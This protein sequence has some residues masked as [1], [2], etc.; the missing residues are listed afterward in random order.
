LDATG[1]AQVLG[2]SS[3][4]LELQPSF[5]LLPG[6]SEAAHARDIQMI[7]LRQHV[8]LELVPV[9]R[10]DLIG[11]TSLNKTHD[12]FRW[13]ERAYQLGHECA[14]QRPVKRGDLIEPDDLS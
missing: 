12:F 9:L 13:H 5:Q 3:R 11:D 7:E 2:K 8:L 6:D 14:T 1:H 10:L 4:G